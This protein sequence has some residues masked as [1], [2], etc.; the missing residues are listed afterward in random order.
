MWTKISLGHVI[1][2]SEIEGRR[3]QRMRRKKST[4][5]CSDEKRKTWI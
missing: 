3:K 1:L 2:E 5:E 4:H